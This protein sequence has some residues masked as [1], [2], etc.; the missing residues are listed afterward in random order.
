MPLISLVI[1]MTIPARADLS[2]LQ[3]ALSIV[4]M[5]GLLLANIIN[6]YL[7]DNILNVQLLKQREAQLNQQVQLQFNK[8]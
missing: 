4:G 7:L 3:A 8:Y 1:L 5:C 2:G 6:Y